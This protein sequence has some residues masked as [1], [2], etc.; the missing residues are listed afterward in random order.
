[1]RLKKFMAV[2]LCATM[3]LTLAGCSFNPKDAISNILNGKGSN[4][5]N[6]NIVASAEKVNKNAVFRE[7]K[8]IYLDGFEYIDGLK[9][10][11]GKFYVAQVV[12]PEYDDSFYPDDDM[13]LYDI[14]EIPEDELISDEVLEDETSG[15]EDEIPVPV[16]VEDENET[17]DIDSEDLDEADFEDFD[18]EYYYDEDYYSNMKSTFHIASFTNESDVVYHD[19]ELDGG[20]EYFSGNNWGFDG[21]ENLYIAV[22]SYDEMTYQETFKLRK[23]SLDGTIIKE[24]P[25]ESGNEEYFYISKIL[26]DEDGTVY[27]VSEQTI[28]CYDKDLNKKFSYKTDIKGGFITN[29]SLKDNGEIIFTV[30][31]WESEEY[32]SKTFKL[33]QQGNATEDAAINSII[34]GKDLLE[35]NGWDF[36]Y[37]NNSSIMGINIGDKEATEVVNF[38][39]SDINPSDL[40]SSIYFASAEQFLTTTENENGSGIL[41]FEKVPAEEVKDKEIITLGTVYGSYSLASQIISFNK[42]NDTYRIKLVDYS[43]FDS[44][45]DFSAGRK[46]FYSDL[47]GGN[48][49]DI[50]VPE[51]YDAANLIDKGV[52]TDL[53]P[54]MANSNGVKKEDLVHNA[55]TVFARDDKLYCVFPTFTVEAIQVKKEFYKEGMNLDD[56]IEW[57]K[58][59]G[60]KA[61]SGDM[62]RS[63]VMSWFMSMSMNEFLDPKTGKCS[64]DSPEF[65]KL[66]EYANTYPKEIGE[67][68]WNNY[69]YSSYLYEF[70]NNKSLLNFAYIDDFQNYNW[71]AKYRF[72]EIPE[73]IGVPLSGKDTAVLNIDA[74]M[75]I[76][77]KSKKKEAAWEFVKSCFEHDY[78]ENIGWGIPS[79]EK[80]LDLKAQK[81]T[82]HQYIEDEN[83]NMVIQD[84]TYFLMDHEETIDPLTQEEVA[85]LKD[86]VVN[87]E[88]L[89]TWDQELNNIIDEETQGYFEGQKSAEEVASIIQSRLQIYINEKK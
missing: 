5:G 25:I 18:D 58:T 74:V 84:E 65:A 9:S 72:G 62:T 50:I 75:G 42:S 15:P 13:I 20:N 8:T 12:Y 23:Y 1:M 56:V 47:T 36:Y 6:A 89:Y 26:V 53:T 34:S 68:Y 71:N 2:S 43:E 77:S 24:A 29:T 69:D 88:G 80:E 78:Y 38:Y 49:C 16:V 63:N 46:R 57:E 4:S 28:T 70:R 73:L 66:L 61:L 32:I 14:E 40:Y 59:T 85:K 27:V 86:F 79:V 48:A 67:E 22:S 76:S 64:F 83:G 7:S 81:A 31:S 52:F 35:G 37:T 55:Q 10:A 21:E 54:L 44:P 30:V 17:E 33:N 60:N 87:V 19:I 82:E 11:N 39:D 3:V 45:D 51:A 41:V